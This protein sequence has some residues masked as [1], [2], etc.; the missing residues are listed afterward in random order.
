MATQNIKV[1]IRNTVQLKDIVFTYEE[2][3]VS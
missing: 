2:H 3:I 1:I